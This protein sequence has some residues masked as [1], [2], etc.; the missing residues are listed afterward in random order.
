MRHTCMTRSGKAG[1]DTLKLRIAFGN[2]IPALLI[3]QKPRASRSQ[4]IQNL[5][6]IRA[7]LAVAEDSETRQDWPG[8]QRQLRSRAKHHENQ[9]EIYL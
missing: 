1:S 3:R 9:T 2:R 5:R 8:E 7:V 4:R 6:D